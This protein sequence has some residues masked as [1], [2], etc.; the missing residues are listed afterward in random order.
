M[1]G[2]AGGG[3]TIGTREMSP[4]QVKTSRKWNCN[5]LISLTANNAS[6][7]HLLKFEETG[8]KNSLARFMLPVPKRGRHAASRDLAFRPFQNISVVQSIHAGTVLG[9]ELAGRSGRPPHP[10]PARLWT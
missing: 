4:F 2:R 9:L 6:A 8:S 3:N 1:R 5:H 10:T 7:G